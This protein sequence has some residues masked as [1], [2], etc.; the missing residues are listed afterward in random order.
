MSVN[1]KKFQRAFNK[2]VNSAD[3]Q[4]DDGNVN[5]NYVDA[6]LCLSGW[7]TKIGDEFY[8]VFD[9]MAGEHRLDQASSRLD[10]LKK[11]YLGQ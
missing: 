1:F 10:V 8:T 6:D 7:D 2:A 3:N 5:W 11:D 4:L 9:Y